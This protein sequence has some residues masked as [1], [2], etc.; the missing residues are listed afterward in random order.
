[1]KQKYDELSDLQEKL[2]GTRFDIDY[3][4]DMMRSLESSA[5]PINVYLLVNVPENDLRL[6]RLERRSSFGKG[7]WHTE[8][9]FSSSPTNAATTI[10][11]EK[12]GVFHFIE[13]FLRMSFN[14]DTFDSFFQIDR[15]AMTWMTISQSHLRRVGLLTTTTTLATIGK[16]FCKTSSSDYYHT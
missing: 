3:S 14:I 6:F 1:M 9:N 5:E 2:D 7:P 12:R 4:D 10:V 8:T 16:R 13:N 11:R 15:S